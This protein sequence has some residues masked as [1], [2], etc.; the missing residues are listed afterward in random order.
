MRINGTLLAIFASLVLSGCLGGGGGS[1]TPAPVAPDWLVDAGAAREHVAG[2]KAYTM[3][4]DELSALDEKLI[5]NADTQIYGGI[6]R[7]L[8][9][10]PGYIYGA[11]CSEGVC[12]YGTSGESDLEGHIFDLEYQPVM[13]HKGIRLGQVFFKST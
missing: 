13:E 7:S 1:V 3:T 8:G 6:Y 4:S 9:E 11:E 12:R 5:T 10:F 2:S